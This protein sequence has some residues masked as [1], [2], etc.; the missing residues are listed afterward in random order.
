[1]RHADRLRG[2]G[3]KDD[4]CRY[5]FTNITGYI[6]YFKN[7]CDARWGQGPWPPSIMAAFNLDGAVSGFTL[8]GLA[9]KRIEQSSLSLQYILLTPT[10]EDA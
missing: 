8:S 10:D 9:D 7:F 5:L 3:G 1:M 4:L 6:P 2:R